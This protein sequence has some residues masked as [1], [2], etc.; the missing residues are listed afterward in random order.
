[1]KSKTNSLLLLF[2]L[3]KKEKPYWH[4]SI[5]IANLS[6]HRLQ[7]FELLGPGLSP[8]SEYLFSASRRPYCCL[9]NSLGT[10]NGW[11]VICEK[12]GDALPQGA[13]LKGRKYANYQAKSSN[14]PDCLGLITSRILRLKGLEWGLNRGW[15][16]KAHQSCDTYERCVY[17]HGTN[18]ERFI[19]QRLSQG[20]L[21]LDND[22]IVKLFDDIPLGSYL[23]I[24]L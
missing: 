19:P 1:M 4:Q 5:L 23:N 22:A 7:V 11:H 15:D 3:L 20:C 16:L 21:L 6:T 8:K 14:H 2:D 17:L 18:L 24:M 13:V 9:K 12:I 10:P